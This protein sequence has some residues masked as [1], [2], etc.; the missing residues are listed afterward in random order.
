MPWVRKERVADDIL[1]AVTLGGGE[2]RRPEVGRIGYEH[3]G[4][5]VRCDSGEGIW[6]N[7]HP[8]Y[9]YGLLENKVEGREWCDGIDE[10]LC[11]GIQ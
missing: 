9:F 6:F 8:E 7:I 3:E 11:C 4:K 2:F 5:F 1:I 10:V